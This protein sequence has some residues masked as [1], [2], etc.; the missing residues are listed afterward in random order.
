MEPI[1]SKLSK[2]AEEK[3]KNRL[4]MMNEYRNYVRRQKSKKRLCRK[5]LYSPKRLPKSTKKL[6]ALVMRYGSSPDSEQEE[7]IDFHKLLN[8]EH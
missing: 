2:K 4:K 7:L 6:K 3:R 1:I 5:L 8:T